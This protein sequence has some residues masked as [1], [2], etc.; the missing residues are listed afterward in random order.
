MPSRFGAPRWSPLGHQEV[1]IELG[2]AVQDH[3][4][5]EHMWA[6]L[7]AALHGSGRTAEALQRF[8]DLRVH[9]ERELGADP[10]PAL[11]A[12]HAAI[13]RGDS[14][15]PGFAVAE[16]PSGIVTFLLMDIVGSS[17]MWERSPRRALDVGEQERDRASRAPPTPFAAPGALHPSQDHKTYRRWADGNLKPSVQRRLAC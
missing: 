17:S 13:V 7:V 3:P 10:S 4:L 2:Q 12:L 8:E 1:V 15:L 6:L 9:L 16:Q 11:C 5:R 14:V